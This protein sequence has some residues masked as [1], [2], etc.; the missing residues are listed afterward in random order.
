MAAEAAA[1]INHERGEK[2]ITMIVGMWLSD[3]SQQTNT[4]INVALESARIANS[5]FP[6]TVEGFVFSQG[7][8]HTS[9]SRAKQTL[10]KMRSIGNV[11]NLKIGTRQECYNII[12][13]DTEDAGSELANVRREILLESDFIIC[14]ASPADH[15][16]NAGAKDGFITVGLDLL[17]FRRDFQTINPRIEVMGQTTWNYRGA[18]KWENLR[19]FGQYW[20]VV[21]EWGK[22]NNFPMWM[23]E[24]IDNPWKNWA[25][26]NG[27]WR[28]KENRLIDRVDGYAENIVDP[29][30]EEEKSSEK[31]PPPAGL[32]VGAWI[33][34]AMGMVVVAVVL[35]AVAMLYFRVGKLQEA[36][37]SDD[38]KEFMY[39]ISDE[40]A[41]QQGGD[42]VVP[43][44][45]KLAYDKSYEIDRDKLQIS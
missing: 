20:Q 10:S 43:S 28:L 19:N 6:G 39:G 25:P 36:I 21:D 30:P 16:R 13:V 24:A 23:L 11:T 44:A 27:W 5:I 3:I 38:V 18:N 41:Q 22:E 29:P 34:L 4:E 1:R 40:A 31:S 14:E 32:S 26:H 12:G 7:D 15:N 45:L 37:T 35:V 2:L 8:I 42:D 9:P 17:G 33:G